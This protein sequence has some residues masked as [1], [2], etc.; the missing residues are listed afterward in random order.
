MHQR[1][2]YIR[3]TTQISKHQ[4][5]VYQVSHHITSATDMVYKENK[6]QPKQAQ[7]QQQL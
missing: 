5:D 4:K 2:K 7:K 1:Q 6:H 3:G